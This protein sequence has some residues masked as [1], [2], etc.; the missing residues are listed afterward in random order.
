MFE[1]YIDFQPPSGGYYD[2]SNDDECDALIGAYFSM[3]ADCDEPLVDK[4]HSQH[5][6]GDIKMFD[7]Y[8]DFMKMYCDMNDEKIFDDALGGIPNHRSLKSVEGYCDFILNT[9]MGSYPKKPMGWSFATKEE[10]YSIL[11]GK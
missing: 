6:N 7:A 11:G 3:A 4:F 9:A 5:R 10:V 8:I 1:A 2:M